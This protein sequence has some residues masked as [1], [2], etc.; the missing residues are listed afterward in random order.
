MADAARVK[1]GDPI[2][3]SAFNALI[4]AAAADP[5][6]LDSLTETAAVWVGQTTIAVTAR[7]GS[8]PGAGSVRIYVYDGS[9]LVDSGVTV[10]ALN[11]SGASG[12][13]P[14]STWCSVGRDGNG[15]WWILSMECV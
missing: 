2:K 9:A 10:D 12:G 8:T 7:S 6:A 14:I 15:R 4:D 11:F 1:P 13:I 5:S 3:A